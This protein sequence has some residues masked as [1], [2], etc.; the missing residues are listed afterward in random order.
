MTES[1][2]S[3]EN[4]LLF[5]LSPTSIHNTSTTLIYCFIE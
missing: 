4:P 5:L 1:Q 3:R 2:K